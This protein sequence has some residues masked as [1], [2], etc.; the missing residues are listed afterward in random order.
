MCPTGH[1]WRPR[2]VM[3]HTGERMNVFV[4][5]LTSCGTWMKANVYSVA[6]GGS[7]RVL[8]AGGRAANAWRITS[9]SE[10][11][12]ERSSHCC[13]IKQASYLFHTL[14]ACTRSS[15]NGG[16]V[17]TAQQIKAKSRITLNSSTYHTQR[18]QHNMRDTHSLLGRSWVLWS[19]VFSAEMWTQQAKEAG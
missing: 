4:Q 5:E 18:Q 13:V 6:C 14:T 7:V 2:C 16:G 17:S 15:L 9:L 12:R 11:T 8:K 1:V 19:C 10:R 3:N